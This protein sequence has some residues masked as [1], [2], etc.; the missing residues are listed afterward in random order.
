MIRDH[1]EIPGE[2]V[3]DEIDGCWVELYPRYGR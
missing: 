1:S 3:F 2:I